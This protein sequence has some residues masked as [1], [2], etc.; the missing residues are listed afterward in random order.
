VCRKRRNLRTRS[1][2]FCKALIVFLI[3]WAIT[4]APFLV[5]SSST[6]GS[7]V[8][9]LLGRTRVPGDGPV[10]IRPPVTSIS[11]RLMASS[12]IRRSW[13]KSFLLNGRL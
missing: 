11:T 4:V 1:K 7:D 8:A 5:L 2:H 6:G 13:S 9:I 10:A 12:N 3:A